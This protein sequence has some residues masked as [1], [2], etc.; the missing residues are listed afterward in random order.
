MTCLRHDL[1]MISLVL[2]GRVRGPEHSRLLRDM[3]AC[4][5]CGGSDGPGGP[6]RVDIA[7]EQRPAASRPT[8]GDRHGTAAEA[9]AQLSLHP[10]GT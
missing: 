2:R 6:S 10:G 7:P 3:R 5:A 8:D 9:G 1:R 4:R